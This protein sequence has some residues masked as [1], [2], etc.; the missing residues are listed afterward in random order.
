MRKHLLLD[1]RD[2]NLKH[3][4]YCVTF[5]HFVLHDKLPCIGGHSKYDMPCILPSFLPAASSNSIPAHIPGANSVGPQN[6]NMPLCKH[7]R[8]IKNVPAISEQKFNEIIYVSNTT[9]SKS[10]NFT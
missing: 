8:N 9:C 6:L 3:L 1:R 7:I 4:S 2:D 5:L 10:K